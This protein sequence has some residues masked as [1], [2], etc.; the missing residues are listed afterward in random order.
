MPFV[1][2]IDDKAV[3][4]EIATNTAD[5]SNAALDLGADYKPAGDAGPGVLLSAVI[6]VDALDKTSGDE[7]YLFNLQESDDGSTGWATIG[8]VAA[9]A[10]GVHVVTARVAKRFLRLQLDLAG[11]TPSITYKARLGVP[12]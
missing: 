5:T 9:D 11:T 2:M 8:S 12:A 3:L 1:P 4:A 7:E 10:V 6:T